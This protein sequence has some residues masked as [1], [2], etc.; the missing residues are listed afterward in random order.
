MH[1]TLRVAHSF[2]MPSLV[3]RRSTRAAF[4]RRV[5]AIWVQPSD[6]RRVRP[7]LRSVLNAW[8]RCPCG[9]G[10]RPRPEPRRE[11]SGTCF[12]CPSARATSPAGRRPSLWVVVRWKWHTPLRGSECP[13]ARSCGRVGRPAPG[14][15]NPSASP[16]G[17]KLAESDVLAGRVPCSTFRRHRDG[18]GVASRYRGEKAGS[19]SAA[20]AC[21]RVG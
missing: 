9:F 8:A 3:R 7:A 2:K 10:R 14:R 6:R 15:A 20:M 19:N 13:C 17:S 11:P 12:R 16:T 4:S 1:D 21:I 18:I 5:W